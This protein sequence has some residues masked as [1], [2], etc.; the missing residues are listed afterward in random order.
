MAPSRLRLWCRKRGPTP[1]LGGNQ[2]SNDTCL[3]GEQGIGAARKRIG[4]I[5]AQGRLVRRQPPE[6]N[7]RHQPPMRP[8]AAWLSGR[9][10][11]GGPYAIPYIGIRLDSQQVFDSFGPENCAANVGWSHKTKGFCLDSAARPAAR[12]LQRIAASTS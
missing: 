9:I 6:V 12:G 4:L 7:G 10:P 11:P 1:F 5:D 3:A 8:Q 2:I